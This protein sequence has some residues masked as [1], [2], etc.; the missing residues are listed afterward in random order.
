MRVR[1][2]CTSLI[3]DKA[4]HEI[5]GLTALGGENDA[6]PDSQVALRI[7]DEAKHG[8]FEPGSTYN[9]DFSLLEAAPKPKE[10]AKAE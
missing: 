5:V 4:N 1:M 10:P 6:H 8:H 2:K 3:K 7:S 9:V